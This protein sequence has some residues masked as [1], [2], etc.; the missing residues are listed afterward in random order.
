[1]FNSTAPNI[2]A[3][4][5]YAELK[6]QLNKTNGTIGKGFLLGQI[7]TGRLIIVEGIWISTTSRLSVRVLLFI[8]TSHARIY[9]LCAVNKLLPA[10]EEI[11]SNN[12]N[13]LCISRKGK[14]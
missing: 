1:M 5:L 11:D 2:T 3:Q 6:R 8:L 14:D 7:E 13:R 10:T 9:M 12:S 4:S